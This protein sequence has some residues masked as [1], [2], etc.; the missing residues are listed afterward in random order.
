[1]NEY[2]I[3]FYTV[4]EFAKLISFKPAQVRKWIREGKINALK[5]NEG[6]KSA[7]RIPSSEL[8]RMHARAYNN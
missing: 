6:K 1:M 8:L 3:K 2:E 7:Y 5:I 4:K